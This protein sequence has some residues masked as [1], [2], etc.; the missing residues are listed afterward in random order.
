[1]HSFITLSYLLLSYYHKKKEVPK[2]FG[3]DAEKVTT[4]DP[5]TSSGFHVRG[6]ALIKLWYYCNEKQLNVDWGVYVLQLD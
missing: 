5:S 4:N 3:I 1:M 6:R 2:F